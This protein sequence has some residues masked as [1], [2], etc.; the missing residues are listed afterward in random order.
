MIDMPQIQ[1][2][3]RMHQDGYTVTEIAKT[4]KLSRPT[5]R[6]YVE[7]DDFNQP[8]PQEEKRPSKLDPY[9]EIVMGWLEE[10]KKVWKKQRHTAQR[11]YDRLK[12]ET[13]YDGSYS[14]VQR[15]MKEMKAK[16]GSTGYLDLVWEPAAVQVDFGQADLYIY[17]V[18]TRMHYLVVTFPYSNVGLAQLFKG[19]NAECVCAGLKSIFEYAGGVPRRAVFD[20]GAGIGKKICD[21]IRLTEL[22]ARFQL[23]YNFEVALCNLDSGNEKGCVEN[24]VGTLRR[25]LFVPVPDIHDVKTYNEMLLIECMNRAYTVHYRKGERSI[26]L[27]EEDCYAMS[28]LPEKPFDCVRYQEYRTDKYG[29][30]VVGKHH[31]YSTSSAMAT[32]KVMV[33]FSADEVSI[34]SLDGALV[35]THDRLYGERPQESIDP[36]ASLRLL[37]KR[38][39]GW[40][41]SN[42]RMSL[43]ESLKHY[44]DAQDKDMRK[45]C[46]ATLAEATETT[47]FTTAVQACWN[48]Y[49]RVGY[50]K[51]SDVSIYAERLWDYGE[52]DYEDP[53]D[54]G[55]YDQVFASMKAVS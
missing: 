33:R 9:K 41:N 53:V 35:A 20:N 26:N 45:E 4:L 22:F 11:V 25:N 3:R 52:I 47:D 24:K 18:L 46:L 36:A 40:L 27:F 17:G 50:I 8:V 43:P 42:V 54:L 29:N 51:R 7:I 16:S 38:P 31:R 34:Y 23:H 1:S 28:P 37:I 39:G 19:E 49:Q 15:F 44:I 2:I 10:D 21:E 55:E 48:V 13:D 30:V 12:T 6:K 5:V 14:L 32:Q